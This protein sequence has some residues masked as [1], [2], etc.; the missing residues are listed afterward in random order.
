MARPAGSARCASESLAKASGVSRPTLN[1]HFTALVG[2]APLGY[3]R[4]WRMTLAAQAL[5]EE[6]VSLARLAHRLGYESEAAFHKAFTRE[7]GATPAQYRK[8]ARRPAR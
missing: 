6:N 7:R 5:R 4:R 1:R 3:L 2:E 8:A